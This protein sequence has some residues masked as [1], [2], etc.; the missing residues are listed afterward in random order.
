MW[1]L[2]I[3]SLLIRVRKHCWQAHDKLLFPPAVI[4]IQSQTSLNSFSVLWE[5]QFF[6]PSH[7]AASLP[8]KRSLKRSDGHREVVSLQQT[9]DL[10]TEELASAQWALWAGR[11]L[12]PDEFIK[13]LGSAGEKK[14]NSPSWLAWRSR[15]GTCCRGAWGCCCPRKQEGG[16]AADASLPGGKEDE[17]GLSLALFTVGV[18]AVAWASCP[19]GGLV[20]LSCL[21]PHRWQT[22]HHGRGHVKERHL[23]LHACDRGWLTKICFESLYFS[24][25]LGFENLHLSGHFAPWQLTTVGS[26][27]QLFLIFSRV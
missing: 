19:E 27:K 14:K 11:R 24:F 5:P 16:A 6:I 12:V 15:G 10:L 17:E 13:R 21:V 9:G 18:V 7:R 25:S 4:N 20:L 23:L 1:I 8:A 3:F 22:Q 2:D 26:I